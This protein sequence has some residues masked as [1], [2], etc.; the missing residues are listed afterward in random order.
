VTGKVV[1]VVVSYMV[2]HNSLAI[3]LEFSE[4]LSMVAESKMINVTTLG[5]GDIL[6][7]LSLLACVVNTRWRRLH[8]LVHFIDKMFGNGYTGSQTLLHN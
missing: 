1:V 2:E 4:L 6:I 7:P 5:T 8:R 3:I